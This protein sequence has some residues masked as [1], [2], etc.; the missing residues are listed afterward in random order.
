MV[1]LKIRDDLTAGALREW[2]RKQTRGRPAARAYAI[3]N[4][5]DSTI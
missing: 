4:V 2:A 5:D 1:A 3:A